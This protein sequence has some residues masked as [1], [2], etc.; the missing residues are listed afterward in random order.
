MKK[1]GAWIPADPASL[2]RAGS[3][4]RPLVAGVE[5]NVEGAPVEVLAIFGDPEVSARQHRVGLTRAIGRQY[6]RA[7]RPHCVHDTGEKIEHADLNRCLLTRMVVAQEIG[8]L[9]ERQCKRA[10]VVSERPIK[11]FAGMGIDELEASKRRHRGPSAGEPW[12]R[13]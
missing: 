3:L 1:A 10:E 13:Q 7:R 9:R 12:Y 4:H 5:T 2:Q 6:D 11:G 8:K